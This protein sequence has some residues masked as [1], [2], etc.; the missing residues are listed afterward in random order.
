MRALLVC[1][2]LFCRLCKCLLIQTWEAVLKLME[3]GS[4]FSAAKAK[5]VPQSVRLHLHLQKHSLSEAEDS[6]AGTYSNDIQSSTTIYIHS[7]LRS[8]LRNATYSGTFTKHNYLQSFVRS[9]TLHNA[10]SDTFTNRIS[11]HE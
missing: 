6:T 2:A 10:I 4:T 9:E 11:M 5:F 7:L 3:K 8:S 1:V